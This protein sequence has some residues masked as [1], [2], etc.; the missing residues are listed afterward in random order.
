VLVVPRVAVAQVANNTITGRV[1]D[2]TGAVVSGAAVTLSQKA[3]GLVLHRKTNG[4]GTYAFPQLQAGTYDVTAEAHG[5]KKT[6]TSVTLTVG[7]TIE[8]D[9][10]LHLGTSTSSVTVQAGSSTQLNTQDATLSYTV[11]TKQVDELPLNGRNPYALATL[12]PGID[13]GGYFGQGLSTTR[14]AVVA[15]ASNNFKTNGGLAGSN[16]IL[17]DGVSIV[18]CCQGQPAVTPSL[19]VLGQFKVVTSNPSA[20]YGRSSGGFLNIVT[21]SGTNKLHGDVYEYFRNDALDAANFF[22]KRSGRYPIP[23]RKDYTLPHHFNQFGAFASGPVV[24]PHL[25]NGKNKT[26]FAFGYEGTRNLAPTYQTTTVPTALMRQGIFTQAPDLI[27]DPNNVAPDPANPGQYVRQPIP[28]ACDN[29]T[30][31]PAGTYIPDINPVA[32][33]LLPLIPAPNAPGVANNYNYTTNVV[34]TDNQLNFRVDHNFTPNQRAFIRGTRDIDDHHSYGLFNQPNEP[35]GWSEALTAYL[36]ELG[37]SWT[38][39][40]SLLFQ[41]NYG[42]AL[43]RNYEHGNS[44]YNFDPESYGFSKLFSSQQQAPGLPYITFNGLQTLGAQTVG[45]GFN[46][47][48][49]Y[50]HSLNA[51][52]ILQHGNQLI[53]FGYNGKMILENAGGLGDPAGSFNFSTTFT[54]GP[55]PNGSVP[56][57]QAA[58]DSWA[59]FLLGYPSSGALARQDTTAFSQFYNALFVQDDWRVLKKLT[60]NLGVR[61]NMETGFKERNNHW[62]DFDPNAKNPLSTYTGL[63]FTGGA[64]YLGAAGSPS[65]AWPT[66]YMFVPRFGFSYEIAPKTVLR[67]GFSILDL[68]TSERGFASGTAGFS[69]TTPYIATINGRTPVNSIDNPFPSGVLLPAGS[70]AGVTVST[71]SGFGALVYNNPVPYQQQWNFGV[72]QRLSRGAIFSLNYVGSHGVHLPLDWRPNDLNPKYFGAPGDQNQVS[73]LQDLVSNPFYGSSATGVL[74]NPQVQRSQLL[75]AFPQYASNNGM[76]NGSLVYD[77]YDHGSASYNAAQALLRVNTNYGLSGS[78]SYTWSKSLGN[79]SSLTTGFLNP[80]NPGIQDFYLIHQYGRS[81]SA[82]DVPQRITGYLVYALPFGK[83]KMLGANWSPWAN[84]IA[85]GW[86]L[87]TILSAQSGF[88]LDLGQTGGEPFSGSRPSYVTGEDPLTSGSTNERLGGAGET[89]GYLNP[90]AFRLSRSFELGDVPRS[91]AAI[92]APGAFEDDASLIKRFGIFKNLN[93]EFRLEAFNFLNKVQFGSPDTTV[94]SSS[95]GDI[96]SQA[97]LPRNVQAALKI[98]F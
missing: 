92:R 87:T 71:G 84:E 9:L 68:P 96:N 22:T 1:T 39:T 7:Q 88:P 56:S 74:A 44:I 79:V 70:S 90:A 25:Y 58:F 27:Y 19:E 8:L 64:Q 18:V 24:I 82:T 36:F 83:G 43:Q 60:L 21:K 28:A 81:V 30:C 11:G 23:G 91:A 15:A 10:K 34:D 33:K 98:F 52:A 31:Y 72:E 67:G 14:G 20:E 50:T 45:S 80:S 47:W 65:R 26:F 59:S 86:T 89:Q 53:T 78:V 37:D 57:G 95:F 38:V 94:G 6:A 97:N 29:G 41:F 5:F 51:I 55:N 63:S 46:L 66:A 75:A 17:L 61:W 76:A 54:N 49:H 42:F 3:T 40:P 16:E 12:A 73:Y 32:Q 13:P 77:Y 62:A 35:T 93:G 85:G 69:Q 48:D 4:T 2:P